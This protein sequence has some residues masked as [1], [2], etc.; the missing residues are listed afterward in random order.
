MNYTNRISRMNDEEREKRLHDFNIQMNIITLTCSPNPPFNPEDIYDHI[1]LNFQGITGVTSPTR[2][3]KITISGIT[4]DNHTGFQHMLQLIYRK[5]DD[6]PFPQG[7]YAH[8]I[9]KMFR[10]GRIAVT[11]CQSR[12][13]FEW[14]M[15]KIQEVFHDCGYTID[16]IRDIKMKLPEKG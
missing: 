12:G 5:P 16:D 7:K 3:K 4:Q 2:R 11:F 9:I 10:T 15:T 14:L 13:E 6:S 8:Y 1:T